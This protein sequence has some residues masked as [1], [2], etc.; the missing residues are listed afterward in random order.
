MAQ[1]VT[2]AAQYLRMSTEHQQYS[3]SNQ[4]R[5]IKR[6]AEENGFEI[7]K[8]YEDLGKSGV[9]LSGREALKSLLTDVEIGAANFTAILVYDVSRWGRFQ[10]A[11]ESA[12]YEYICRRSGTSIHYC[13]EQFSNDC[14]PITT[15]MKSI[16]RVM[17]GEYSRELS[18]RVFMGQCRIVE[19]GYRGGGTPGIGYRRL[20]VDQNGQAKGVLLPGQHKSVHKDRISLIPGP[21]DEVQL[22]RRIFDLFV[23][24]RLNEYQIARR[25]NKEGH[26]TARGL[27]WHNVTIRHILQNEKYIGHNIYHKTTKKLGKKRSSVEP[28]KWIRADNAFEAIVDPATFSEAQLLF[29]LRK[30]RFDKEV[31]LQGLARLYSEQGKITYENIHKDKRI[32][33]PSSYQHYFGNMFD[34]YK[35]IGFSNKRIQATVTTRKRLEARR[36][37]LIQEALR[38]IQSHG[39][40]ASQISANTILANSSVKIQFNVSAH[41]VGENAHGSRYDRWRI[42]PR[43]RNP[44]DIFVNARM[45][46]GNEAVLDY[47]V[48]PKLQLSRPSFALSYKNDLQWDVFR[49][50]SLT[51]LY[52]LLGCSDVRDGK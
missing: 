19:E 28:Q 20:L 27:H 44:P 29:D 31:M 40:T 3:I 2:P 23:N 16:K 52:G 39:G 37:R 36:S 4:A 7:V 30:K 12:Y 51:R 26:V 45:A 48:F 35:Q 15:I 42:W 5:V 32:P 8:T 11:D 18:A 50:S 9:Q 43:F 46:P 14:T 21:D 33:S 34:L 41:Y 22:V 17:A 1:K 6:Y 47:Y 38:Y 25:L 13:A 10:D 24:D 49:Y